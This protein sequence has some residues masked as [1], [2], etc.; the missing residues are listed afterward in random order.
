MPRRRRE[1]LE[2]GLLALSALGSLLI[3]YLLAPI[4]AL[5]LGV[6]PGVLGE[7]L[8][9]PTLRGE[10]AGAF[11]V[12]L[13][14]SL[15]AVGLLAVLGVPLAYTLARAEFPGK[16][17]V[18]GLVDVPLALPHTV[19]GVMILEAYGRRGLL[20]PGLERLGVEVEDH[21]M[22]VVLVMAFVS[23]P[24]LVDTAKVGFQ[25]V[26]PTLEAVARTLG[27]S[28]LRAFRDVTLPLAA[29][30]IA[31][32]AL[33][34]WARGLSEVG[35]LLVVAYYPKTVNILILEYLSVYGLPY[36]VALSALYAALTLAIFASLRVVMRR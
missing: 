5:Y 15:A 1:G 33:L 7:I 36:A 20:G 22:G 23:A 9:Q 12:A 29:R 30:S 16:S 32:G 35:G 26:P 8:S 31:A 4:M 10:V 3:L 34:A 18:E 17:V 25:S 28:R 27:A 13:E 19:A 14:A 21:F 6:E 24:L 11:R 2:P